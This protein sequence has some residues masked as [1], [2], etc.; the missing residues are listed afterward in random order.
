MKIK[1]FLKKIK[2]QKQ[3]ELVEESE[4]IKNSYLADSESYLSSAKIL[5]KINKL[6][7]TT[8][9][10]YFSAYYSLLALLFRIGIKSE[11]H[12]A[13]AILLKEIFN[14]NNDFILFFRKKR[15]STYYSDFEIEKK[16]LKELI[17]KTEDFN[18]DL[19]HFISKLNNKDINLYRIKFKSL[20]E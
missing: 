13:S 9:L 12:L 19:L 11:N 4:E 14:I 20:F 10:L 2:K 1:S 7:E 17:E 3:I 8:Q 6:K 16:N 18:D 5:F 15:I